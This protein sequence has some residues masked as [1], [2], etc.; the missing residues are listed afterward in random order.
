MSFR[1]SWFNLPIWFEPFKLDIQFH[2]PKKDVNE[3]LAG[4]GGCEHEC[5]NVVGNFYC[6]CHSGFELDEN[7]Q[8]CIGLYNNLLDR[9][10][11]N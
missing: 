1:L 2:S 7:A 3:C 10:M 5:V 6:R 8:N 11:A 9:K 4:N